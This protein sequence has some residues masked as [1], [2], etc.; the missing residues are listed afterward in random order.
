[1]PDITVSLTDTQ[2][3]CLE[4]DA[5]T[6]TSLASQM[7]T[8]HANRKKQSVLSALLVHCNENNIALA[9]GEDAQVTQAFTL[10]IVTRMADIQSAPPSE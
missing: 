1:M 2:N 3:K 10:G 5:S 4:I 9:T 7:I 8:E 6:A